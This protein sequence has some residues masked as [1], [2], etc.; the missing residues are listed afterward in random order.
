MRISFALDLA[1]DS[2]RMKEYVDRVKGGAPRTIDDVSKFGSPEKGIFGTGGDSNHNLLNIT[3]TP[4]CSLAPQ[5]NEKFARAVFGPLLLEFQFYRKP[6]DP[7]KNPLLTRARTLGEEAD[8]WFSVGAFPV[9][10]RFQAFAIG[11][12]IPS[13][14]FRIEAD[15]IQSDPNQWHSNGKIVGVPDLEGTQMFVRVNSYTRL[16][17]PVAQREFANCKRQ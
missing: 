15:E 2:S 6:I 10:Q 14:Q 9:P 13:G 16:D 12:D 8:L 3:F 17:D 1:T 4:K 7:L 11:Y 5:L